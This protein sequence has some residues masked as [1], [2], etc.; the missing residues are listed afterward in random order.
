MQREKMMNDDKISASASNPATDGGAVSGP[1]PVFKLVFND[2]GEQL[3]ITPDVYTVMSND[4]VAWQSASH[5]K[6]KIEFLKWCP[7]DPPGAGSRV[8]ESDDSG[9]LGGQIHPDATGR[10]AY[11]A[12]LLEDPKRRAEGDLWV[13]VRASIVVRGSTVPE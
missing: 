8:L 4:R 5:R 7:F 3:T 10:C 9:K 13:N 12:V 2:A 11:N 1:D 6:F